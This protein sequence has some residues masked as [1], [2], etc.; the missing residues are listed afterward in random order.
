MAIVTEVPKFSKRAIGSFVASEDLR[1]CQYR[2]LMGVG[3]A[4][5][6]TQVALNT[7]DGGRIVGILLNQ[8]NVGEVAEVAIPTCE[9]G[10]LSA[11]TFNCNVA[12]AANATGYARAATTSDY[13]CAIAKEASLGVSHLVAVQVET[14]KI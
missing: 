13:V 8:P 5:G 3:A 6:K 7:V 11:G 12:L 2:A 1:A 10:W 14:Y 9:T 4:S